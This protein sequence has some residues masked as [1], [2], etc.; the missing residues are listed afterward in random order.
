MMKL[1]TM[2]HDLCIEKQFSTSVSKIIAH[3]RRLLCCLCMKHFLLYSPWWPSVSLLLL[4][5]LDITV[6]Y[7]W[8]RLVKVV[9]QQLCFVIL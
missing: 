7:D 3:L 9:L 2:G 8:W 1:I 5:L 4:L 6:M